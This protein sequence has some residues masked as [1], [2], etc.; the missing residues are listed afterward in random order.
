[1]RAGWLVILVLTPDVASAT[2]CAPSTHEEDLEQASRV[3]AGRVE[4][5]TLVDVPLGAESGPMIAASVRITDVW[6]GADVEVLTVYTHRV[7]AQALALHPGQDWVFYTRTVDGRDVAGGCY[8]SHHTSRAPGWL[9]P[10][11]HHRRQPG[12]GPVDDAVIACDAN[13]TRERIA[14]GEV[15]HPTT[16]LRTL[17]CPDPAAMVAA[18]GPGDAAWGKVLERVVT[19]GDVDLV[20][21]LLDAG[22][23]ARGSA[24]ATPLGRALQVEHAGMVALLRERG[25]VTDAAALRRVAQSCHTSVR[26][27]FRETPLTPDL[28]AE[29]LPDV[30]CDSQL[31][32]VVLGQ[33]GDATPPVRPFL[34]ALDECPGARQHPIV[35]DLASRMGAD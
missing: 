22:I 13:A 31:L 20:R 5:V 8:G 24:D 33:L 28:A 10:P 26:R 21:L 15:L 34:D 14:A 30:L 11:T 27:V 25:A 6:K 9:G 1:M 23:D 35:S 29:L 2:S 18:I 3:V 16:H 12:H 19:S 4:S 7:G 17:A 32:P